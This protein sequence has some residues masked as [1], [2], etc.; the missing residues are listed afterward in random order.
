MQESQTNLSVC[1]SMNAYMKKIVELF[2]IF[3][4]LEIILNFTLSR[5]AI[6][7]SRLRSS[8]FPKT[9]I[10]RR[11]VGKLLGLYAEKSSRRSNNTNN[12]IRA[13]DANMVML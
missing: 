12:N 10:G 7:F 2:Y 5:P 6:G 3:K 8:R 11:P 9:G 13:T 1:T 4:I